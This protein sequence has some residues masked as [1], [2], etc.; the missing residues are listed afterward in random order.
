MRTP[1]TYVIDYS[2]KYLDNEHSIE[3]FRE[4]PP[5]L[6]HIGKSVPILHNWGPV[7]LICGENQY[8][9]GPDHTLNRDA[10]RLLTPDEVDQR[11]EFLKA[12]TKKWHE[13]G[14]PLLIPYSS[15]NTIAGDHEKRNGFWEFYDHWD[16]YKKYLGPKP[17]EDPFQWLMVD[18]KGNFLPGCCGGYSPA[19]FAPL[20]RYMVCPEYPEWKRFQ[21]SLTELI[22][23]VGYDGIFIDN[24]T[25]V[26]G[27]TCFCKYCQQ[28]FKRYLEKLS[29]YEKTLLGVRE[30]KVELL[31]DNLPL[32]LLCRFRIDGI[33]RYLSLIGNTG[34]KINP[35]FKVF[36][37]V[38][39]Y[40]TFM[41]VSHSCNFLM[42][43]NPYL[44]GINF[45]KMEE[46][47]PSSGNNHISNFT[48]Q[49][50]IGQLLF[51][52]HA[53]ARIVALNYESLKEGREN[54]MELGL[55]ECS[56][57]SNGG[58]I[59]VKGETRVKY[60]KFFKKT[61]HLYEGYEPYS[62]IG[63]LYSYW[64]HNPGSMGHQHS[65]E[66]NPADDIGA[67][68]RLM[69]VLMDRTLSEVS[70][71]TLKTLILCGYKLELTTQQIESIKKFK[72]DG[73]SLYVYL[74]ETSVN[75]SPFKQVFQGV[76]QWEPGTIVPGMK[77]LTS[78]E[79]PLR[80]LR[81]SA[82]LNKDQRSLTLHIVNYNL[83]CQ[84][85]PCTVTEVKNVHISLPLPTGFSVDTIK[86]YDPDSEDVLELQHQ[87]SKGKLNF[88]LENLR[89]YK[90]I[91]ISST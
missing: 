86:V 44:P 11:I 59:A 66:V 87:I 67:S 63:L 75:N 53:P 8:T 52:M 34:R 82:F 56:A 4:S 19:Y 50:H 21:S 58:A 30:K 64:G 32:E 84:E 85:I 12:Y 13:I 5:D 25:P 14:V 60:A 31:M 55:A 40:N 45:S 81:F 22:A 26:S 2:Q 62:D 79:G 33:A 18:K 49:T 29:G 43:E 3:S 77:P 47:H 7:P 42:F 9:G 10:I 83:A 46:S 23:R 20:H 65:Q 72:Q 89:I 51:T 74:P 39:S 68:H 70:L 36:A 88:I 38:N 15:I 1:I 16:D 48:Y 78:S 54:L 91:V 71:K 73:G 6:I 37:N 90:L 61:L 41:P 69:E 24:A 28:E 35:D 27:N 80:G 76:S 17:R 57:F